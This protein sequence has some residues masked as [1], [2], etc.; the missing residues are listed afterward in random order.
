MIGTHFPWPWH[1]AAGCR[2]RGVMFIFN[3]LEVISPRAQTRT[4][5]STDLHGSIR[6]TSDPTPKNVLIIPTEFGYFGLM[7]MR[8]D[9]STFISSSTFLLS[10]VEAA[11]G[12]RFAGNWKPEPANAERITIKSQE[13]MINAK[14]G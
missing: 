2:R 7:M 11:C 4:R 14:N 5:S 13:E 3:I 1:G 6:S 10:S 12:K 8:C 9:G